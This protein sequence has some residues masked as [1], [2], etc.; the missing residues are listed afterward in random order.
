MLK[1]SL[2]AMFATLLVV[3]S[4]TMQAAE[5]GAEV[6]ALSKEIEALK[7]EVDDLGKRAAN[8]PTVIDQ[9]RKG[10]EI[11]RRNISA[12]PGAPAPNAF[13]KG[14]VLSVIAVKTSKEEADAFVK[15]FSEGPKASHKMKGFLGLAVAEHTKEPGSFVVISL[16]ENEEALNGYV[17]SKAF[18]E[19]H[20]RV[21]EVKSAKLEPPGRFLIKDH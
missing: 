16:W 20:A 19:D 7:K 1:Y 17:R 12:G 9:I 4:S 6:E 14:Q 13:N 10:L 5:N 3:G 2:F 11:A 21:G 15:T 8:D 18:G